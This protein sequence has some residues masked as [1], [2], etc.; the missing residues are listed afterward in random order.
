MWDEEGI[1]RYRSRLE[2]KKFEVREDIE[3]M[4]AELI[5]LIVEATEKRKIYIWQGR[6]NGWNGECGEL[7]RKA[8]EKLRKWNNNRGRKEEYLQAREN[9][10]RKCEERKREKPEEE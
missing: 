2:K 7:K 9:Y 4:I 6:N 5:N 1:Q 3:A 8:R 10:R